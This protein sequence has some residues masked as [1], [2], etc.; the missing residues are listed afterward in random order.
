MSRKKNENE[1]N[2]IPHF[3]TL[4]EIYSRS[5]IDI[6]SYYKNCF[7]IAYKTSNNQDVIDR[8]PFWQFNNMVAFLEEF[9]TEENGGKKKEKEEEN[10]PMSYAKDMIGS[11]MKNAKGMMGSVGMPKLPKH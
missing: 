6:E 4:A 5:K 2:K 8:L 11:A 1:E 7:L 3:P 10:N 9:L